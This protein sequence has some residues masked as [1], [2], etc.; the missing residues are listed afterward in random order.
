M[1]QI[2]NL[3]HNRGENKKSLSCHHPEKV[4]GHPPAK[5]RFQRS[6]LD[7]NRSWW[8]EGGMCL[9]RKP[10]QDHPSCLG[11][12]Y[13][14]DPLVL[15]EKPHAILPVPRHPRHSDP[16]CGSAIWMKVFLTWQHTGTHRTESE[17]CIFFN[18][19]T[20]TTPLKNR[21]TWQ[22]N[23]NHDLVTYNIIQ[24]QSHHFATLDVH[25]YIYISTLASLTCFT[26]RLNERPPPPRQKKKKLVFPPESIRV[27]RNSSPGHFQRQRLQGW[28]Q[29]SC[30]SQSLEQRSTKPLAEI[31]LLTDWFIG[32]LKMYF[33]FQDMV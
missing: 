33:C 5:P 6:T 1:S 13:W 8:N 25:V 27:D 26:K 30:I 20:S 2:G 7:A 24:S 17:S 4:I 12:S 31:P 19:I 15:F 23:I 3:P 10:S 16:T 11:S 28:V 32:I 18:V 9:T 22:H 21:A 14:K 29:I